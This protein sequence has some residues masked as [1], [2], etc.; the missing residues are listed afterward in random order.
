MLLA[1]CAIYDTKAQAF[2]P[3]FFA[4]TE[5]VAIRWFHHQIGDIQSDLSKYPAD[6][7]LIRLGTF[8][9]V[10][11]KFEIETPRTIA[12]GLSISAAINNSKRNDQ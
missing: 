3:P 4:R 5:E 9:D 10:N 12:L 6:Y 1:I 8:D 11:A 7:N 2:Q